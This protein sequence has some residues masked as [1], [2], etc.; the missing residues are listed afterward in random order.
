MVASRTATTTT[1]SGRE[2]SPSERWFWIIDRISPANC[3]GRVRV[4]GRLTTEQ[5]ERATAA[6]LAEYPLL[7]MGVVDTGDGH[8]RA[9]P[10]DEPRI[11]LRQFGCAEHDAWQRQIDTEMITPIE[12]SAGF[13]RLTD[14]AYAPGTS[15]EYHDLVLTISHIIVDGRS[16]M[17]VLRKII[18]YAVRDEIGRPVAD[19]PAIAPSDD[20]IPAAARG[21]WRYAYTT[22]LD[23][24]A[25]LVLRPRRLRGSA[26]VALPDRLTRVV[27]RKVPAELL[28]VLADDCRRAGVT[29]HGVLAAA[30][31]RAIGE[32]SGS[33]RGIAGIGS[34]V[35]FR[36]LLD[37]QPEP[38]ELGN[39]APVLTTF[40]RYG[41]RNSPWRAARSVN[42]QL[43]RGVRQRRHLSTVAGMRFGTPRTVQTGTRIVEMVDR[44][45][46]WNVSVTNLGRLDFPEEIDGLGLSGLTVAAT[47]SCVSA[48]TVAIVTAHEEMRIAFCYV[49]GVLDAV[50]AD[51]F[52]DRVIAEI[53]SRPAV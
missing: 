48:L 51:R 12:V 45:A 47:N 24:A 46:P 3:V 5:I 13:A 38:D 42:R 53:I 23:Q 33:A 7:R 36:G 22:L 39:Y 40:V 9:E 19:R 10:L 35:D 50:Q 18:E 17:T 44:R 21:F 8:P 27:H 15:G 14:I 25:A 26:P 16:L 31:A 20:L 49:D 41:A 2:L 1:D 28:A 11:P 4:H 52:A 32:A 37:P 29:V 6:V 30:V 43:A 34:P